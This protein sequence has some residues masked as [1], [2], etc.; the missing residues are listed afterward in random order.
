MV[1]RISLYWISPVLNVQHNKQTHLFLMQ[2]LKQSSVWIMY[3]D[4]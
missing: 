4:L 1:P 3:F 2:M